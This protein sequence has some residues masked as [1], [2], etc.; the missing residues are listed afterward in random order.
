VK[1]TLKTTLIAAAAL[2]AACGSSS[3][4]TPTGGATLTRGAVTAKAA[5][6]ITVNGVQLST[7]AAT[8]RV[9]D[10]PG[11]IDD[12]KP[13]DVVTVKGTFDDRTGTAAE[14]E[15]EHA[16]EGRVDDKG[17]DFVVVGGERIQVDDSTDFGPDHPNGLDSVF[18]GSVVQISG[19]PVAGV[20]GALDDKGGLRA[21]RIELSPRN[22]GNPAD[23][24]DLD[25]KGFVSA[26]DAG[27]RTFQLRATPDAA[28]YYV[29]G[30]AT[31]P[32]GVVDGAFVE[33]ATTVAPVA[34]TPP[35]IS[36]L[37]ASAIHVEDSLAG[38]EAEIE[39]YVT[40]LSGSTFVAG[41]V[42]IVTS[43]ATQYALGTA[44]DL[45]PGVKVE[46]EGSVDASGVL[47]ASKVTFRSGIRIT[48]AVASYTGTAMT[49][50]GIPVQVPSWLRNDLS[51]ALANGVR[52]E[53]RGSKTADGSGVV[54]DRIVD[55]TGG[56]SRVFIR[57]TADAKGTDNVTVFGFAVSLA[58][59]NLLY[60]DGSTAPSVAAFLANVDPGRTVLKVRA[61]S[62]A[63]V[64]SG[65][66]TWT[67]DEVEIEG[68]D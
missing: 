57:A 11:G 68:N 66:K 31:L 26:L 14:I 63:N 55:P 64:N 23:D 28:G 53:V 61:S 45:L 35:V 24:G 46:V 50:L 9:D 19:M 7:S 22:G 33:V 15:V 47:H 8:V 21:S 43:G 65:A 17:I 30:Y 62:A 6:T 41:G 10:H 59:A 44:G 20:P 18:I 49:L 48:A 16:I 37:V 2:L 42:T 12:V 60:A 1:R 38:T 36:S 54:A 58:G 56:A 67:A 39:G 29:V 34:G 3:S 52:I 32:A 25:V 13:G 51:V 40:S 4:T 5:S 27:A